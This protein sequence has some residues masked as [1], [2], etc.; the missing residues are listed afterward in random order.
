MGMGHGEYLYEQAPY[1]GLPVAVE[2]CSGAPSAN[3]IDSPASQYL[4]KKES[5]R[6]LLNI[7]NMHGVIVANLPPKKFFLYNQISG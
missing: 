1:L 6:K 3:Q 7:N 4:T 2:W 5:M